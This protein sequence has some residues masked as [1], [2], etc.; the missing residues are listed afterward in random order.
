MAQTQ[1]F[2]AKFSSFVCIAIGLGVLSGCKWFKHEPSS[3]MSFQEFQQHVVVIDEAEAIA[4]PVER[5]LRYPTPPGFKWSRA[6]IEGLCA[7]MHTPVDHLPDIKRMIDAKDWAGL[8][9]HYTEILRRHYS[10]EDPEYLIH[11]SFPIH[12]WKSPQEADDYTLRWLEAAPDDAYANMTRGNLL[13]HRAWEVRGGNFSSKTDQKQMKNA[14]ALAKEAATLLRNASILQPRLTPAYRTLIN[15]QMLVGDSEEI[16]ETFGRAIRQSSHSYYVRSTL[17][18]FLQPKWGGSLSDM[19]RLVDESEPYLARNPRLALLRARRVGMEGERFLKR[20]WYGNALDL[21]REA[22]EIA[23]E[24]TVLKAAANIAYRERR[25][26]QAIVYSTQ[27][28]RFS[29][30]TADARSKR[31]AALEKI[32]EPERAYCDYQAAIKENPGENWSKRRIS[33]LEQLFSTQKI[34]LNTLCGPDN[35]AAKVLRRKLG[36]P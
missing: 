23:P 13:D 20:E 9:A 33:K 29:R 1:R 16:G 21:Y 32:G 35:A 10:G 11:R 15:T 7:D 34:D 12:S 27:E 36:L 6:L 24:D 18:H 14:V 31:G 5:C 25:Y 26:V 19:D 4:D 2:N 28:I 30:G 17:I 3:L 8:E 22:L